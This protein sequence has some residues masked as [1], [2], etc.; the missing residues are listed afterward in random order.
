MKSRS[1][2][3]ACEL[4][5]NKKHCKTCPF[6][7]DSKGIWRDVEQASVV[8][9]RTLFRSHQICHGTEGENREARTR[10]KGSFDH[11]KEIYDRT[12]FGDLVK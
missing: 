10:C 9:Q 3:P 6:R 4:P 11:N 1:K 2:V 12:G 8:T 7:P 5:V